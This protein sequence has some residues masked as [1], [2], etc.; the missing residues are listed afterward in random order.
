MNVRRL[1]VLMALLGASQCAS[2]EGGPGT[3]AGDAVCVEGP[4]DLRVLGCLRRGQY[5]H[6]FPVKLKKK[7]NGIPVNRRSRVRVVIITLDGRP[8]GKDTKRPFVAVVDGTTLSDGAH[9]LTADIRLQV[10]K[11]NKK[12]RKRFSFTFSACG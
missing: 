10:P 4:E 7:V 1:G 12:F 8:N 5:A 6:R 11:T 2:T 9:V 3:V